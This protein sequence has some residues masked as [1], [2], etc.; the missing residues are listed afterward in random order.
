MAE[1]PSTDQ[2]VLAV[3]RAEE[4]RTA[5]ATIFAGSNWKLRFTGTLPQTETVLN[6]SVVR[7]VI[8]EG[9]VSD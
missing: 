6:K 9:W 4:D 3:F 2:I 5:L 7:V 8:S 1:K